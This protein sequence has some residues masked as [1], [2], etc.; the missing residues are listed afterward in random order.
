MRAPRKA[1]TILGRSPH[2]T[3]SA[4]AP[5]RRCSRPPAVC[6]IHVDLG[7][8]FDRRPRSQRRRRRRSAAPAERRADRA[9][10][11]KLGVVGSVLYVAAHPDDENTAL[12]AY[13]ANGARVRDRL[14]V[15]HA[16]RRRPEP[17]RL[18]ARAGAGPDP[19][20]GAAGGAPH[21]RRRAVLHARA[22]LRL[23]EEPRRDAA[24][25]GA[26]AGARRRRARS[27]AGFAPT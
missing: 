24:D 11:R 27:S 17:D 12:L 6:L 14:P 23:L 2:A 15:D 25:L 8:G 18:R 16:R 7:L 1:S 13:L 4:H 22:R 5:S 19:H 10:L 20:A 9:G 3:R 21:R 26:E